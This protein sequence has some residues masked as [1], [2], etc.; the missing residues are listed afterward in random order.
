[1]NLGFVLINAVCTTLAVYV[2]LW[3]LDIRKVCGYDIYV[4]VIFTMVLAIFY[5][6]TLHGALIAILG[7]LMLSILLIIT[8]KV[9]GRVHRWS[10]RRMRWEGWYV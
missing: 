2:V 1:M 5:M 7:G 9:L 4:D 8:K 6:G 3:K 10:W